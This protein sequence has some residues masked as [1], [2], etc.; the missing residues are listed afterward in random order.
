MKNKIVIAFVCLLVLLCGCNKNESV[1]MKTES[2]NSQDSTIDNKVVSNE[3]KTPKDNS[4]EA[5]VDEEKIDEIVIEE[6]MYEFCM[7]GFSF[8]CPN[9]FWYI[10]NQS[11]N[12]QK[13]FEKDNGEIIFV[14]AS[15]GSG[16]W[17]LSE[18][19]E[20]NE[21]YQIDTQYGTATITS[22]YSEELDCN[23]ERCIFTHE[24][25]EFRME[26]TLVEES[27]PLE[28]VF[29]EMFC[30]KKES[31]IRNY[32]SKEIQVLESEYDYIL[33]D[34]DVFIKDGNEE[35]EY[36]NLFGFNL[37]DNIYEVRDAGGIGVSDREDMYAVQDWVFDTELY[38]SMHI[39]IPRDIYNIAC[40]K[41]FIETNEYETGSNYLKN[42]EQIVSLEKKGTIVTEYGEHE[43][44]YA[45]I[46][47]DYGDGYKGYQETEIV[48]L[49]VNEKDILIQYNYY[50]T[51]ETEDDFIGYQ[52]RIKEFF[53][54]MFNVQS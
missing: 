21:E 28:L 20:E 45:K 36:I 43:I 2:D 38:G 11:T 18:V 19:I 33:S 50:P 23:V 44:I 15:F 22:G 52:E 3:E 27:K 17:K 8:N 14:Y 53:P 41:K 31:E 13:Y 7:N 29:E 39:M 25:D 46:S 10:Q 35:Y 6:M 54:L 49:N 34:I 32:E 42:K 48:L 1:S 4:V 26:R 30:G 12:A 47:Y 40:L 5:V 9:E 16:R 24:D 37:Q 51:A